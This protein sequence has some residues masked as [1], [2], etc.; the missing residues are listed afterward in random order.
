MLPRGFRSSIFL[1]R[2]ASR[3]NL[4]R[5]EIGESFD[6]CP[7]RQTVLRLAEFHRTSID[8]L[9]GLTD[10]QEPYPRAKK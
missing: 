4:F 1:C 2:E 5:Q 6:R 3:R 10:L 9:L 7:A 8:Y